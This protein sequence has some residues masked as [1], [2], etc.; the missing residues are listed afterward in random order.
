MKKSHHISEAVLWSTLAM[1]QEYMLKNL[2]SVRAQIYDKENFVDEDIE[3]KTEDE[4]QQ[5]VSV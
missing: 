2:A 1:F 3:E 4:C 5:Q